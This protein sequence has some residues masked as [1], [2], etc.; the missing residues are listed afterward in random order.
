MEMLIVSAIMPVIFFTVFANMS[1]GMRAWQA[2][3]RPVSEEETVTFLDRARQDFSNAFLY[4]S[5][6]FTGDVTSVEFA[7]LVPSPKELGGERGIGLVGYSFDEAHHTVV[8][9]ESNY[10]EV[11]KEAP[12]RTRAV[13]G[14]VTGLS[15]EYLVFQPSDKS[16]LWME[17]FRPAKK[18]LP[19]AVRL[20]ITRAGETLVKTFMVPSGN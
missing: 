15:I 5:I 13:L 16:F 7:G 9:A 4:A 3:N 10:S 18:P 19:A 6:P 8:R 20:T 2:F 14:G 1:S 11:Y 17:E 12:A